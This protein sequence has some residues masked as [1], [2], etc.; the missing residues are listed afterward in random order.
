VRQFVPVVTLTIGT[1]GD[2]GIARV[3]V[4]VPIGTAGLPVADGLTAVARPTG[5]AEGAAVGTEAVAAADV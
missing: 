1:A 5:V 3:A 4:S 2:A